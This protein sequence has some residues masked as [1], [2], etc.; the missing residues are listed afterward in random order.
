MA[1][2]PVMYCSHGSPLLCCKESDSATWWQKAGSLAR[3]AGVKGV[4]LIGAHWEELDDRIRV[5]TK[6]NPNKVQMSLVPRK[7]WENYQINVD[8][9]LARKVI[10]L[11]QDQG[12]TDVDEDPD[13]DWH[14]DTI[15]PLKWMFPEGTPPATVISMNARF[16]AVFHVRIGQAIRSLSNQ[17]I[18]VIGSGGTVHN[19]YRNNWLPLRWHG[20]NFQVGNVP[21]KWATDFERAISDVIRDNQGASLAGALVRL[22][23]HPKYP[24]AHPTPDHYY[25]LL[26]IAGLM[27]DRGADAPQGEMKAQTWELQNMCNNQWIWG[28]FPGQAAA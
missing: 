18:L 13:F 2:M 5:A 24:L 28:K 4:V 16:D 19:L 27:A 15:T 6:F 22:V 12:F 14:D 9:K 7:H 20:D 17:G 26:V 21:A 25:P 23:Q 1:A 8:P 3:D 10:N 11:L